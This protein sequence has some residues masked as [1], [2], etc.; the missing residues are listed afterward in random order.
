MKLINYF[1]CLTVL[2]ALVAGFF[3]WQSLYSSQRGEALLTSISEIKHIFA[4]QTKPVAVLNLNSMVKDRLSVSAELVNPALLLPQTG[5]YPYSEFAA[6]QQYAQSCGNVPQVLKNKELDKA[7]LWAKFRCGVITRLPTDFFASAP[8]MHPSGK[9]YALLAY[10]VA[11]P[12]QLKHYFHLAE[13][14]MPRIN[15]SPWQLQLLINGDNLVM[16]KDYA[17]MLAPT[18]TTNTNRV[19]T[20]YPEKDWLDFLA[21][22]KLTILTGARSQPCLLKEGNACWVENLDYKTRVIRITEFF[23]ILTIV[24]LCILF[25]AAIFRRIKI[26]KA[27]NSRRLFALQ[28]LTHELRTPTASMRLSLESLR[29]NYDEL[30][31]ESQI[32]FLRLCEELQR[33]DRL[34]DASKAYL[35]TDETLAEIYL[36]EFVEAIIHSYNKP[37]EFT[38]LECDCTML[39]NPYSLELCVRNL[40]DNAFSH[41][42]APVVVVLNREGYE[43]TIQVQDQGKSEFT[44]MNEMAKPFYK[45]HS[46]RGLGLGLAIVRK[47]VMSMH[48]ELFYQANPTRFTI[49]LRA[50]E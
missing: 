48:G 34:A 5:N 14:L 18:S 21:G 40:I 32:A 26:R 19:Y 30:P 10:E 35:S 2:I 43:I 50:T 42:S 20:L 33:L 4:T 44:S 22:Q 11:L 49:Q 25:L 9:S 3:V 8:Y 29:K 47:I 27:E 23:L 13:L 39:L 37:I 17:F 7:L 12:M 6:V 16:N 31:Q 24:L 41:G 46:S 38:R 45:S 28:M 15:L 1:A 36:N